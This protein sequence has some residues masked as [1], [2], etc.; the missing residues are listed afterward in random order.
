M[1][2]RPTGWPASCCSPGPAEG[3]GSRTRPRPRRSP[4]ASGGGRA[5]CGPV[6][7]PPGRSPRRRPP[8][9]WS[10]GRPGRP[11]ARRVPAD[12][13]SGC[14]NGTAAARLSEPIT[15]AAA[16]TALSAPMMAAREASSSAVSSAIWRG[17]AASSEKLKSTTQGRP[18]PSATMLAARSE[19][20]AIRARCSP[21]ACSHSFRSIVS[22]RRCT[23]IWSREL[24]STRSIT[25]SADPSAVLITCRTAGTATPARSAMT[26]ASAECST[27]WM[28]EAAGRVSPTS[29]SRMNRYARYSRSA[30]R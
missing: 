2:S 19:R 29:R 30:S 22:L 6:P 18:A 26:A 12:R 11:T 20:C 15:V 10:A 25:S 5:G 7:G 23:G 13:A 4:A 27:A 3:A 16:A 9:S 17:V 24:P 21:S 14:S 1:P 28:S 8:G